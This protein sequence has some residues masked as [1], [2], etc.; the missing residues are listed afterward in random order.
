MADAVGFEAAIH[1][2]AVLTLLSGVVVG[3]AMSQPT[4]IRS[5]KEALLS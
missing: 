1:L 5:A 3:F 2:V 4:S